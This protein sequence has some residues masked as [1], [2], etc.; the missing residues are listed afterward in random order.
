MKLVQ[1]YLLLVVVLL[2]SVSSVIAQTKEQLEKQR[3]EIEKEIASLEKILGKTEKSEK[4]ALQKVDE[5]NQQIKTTEK[6]I[7][8]NNQEA[9]LLSNQIDENTRNIEQLKKQLQAL[10]NEYAKMIKKSYQS[11]S[12]QNRIMFLFSSESF[13]QAYKRI[14]YMNQHAN[15]RKKQGLEIGKQTKELQRLNETLFT[16]KKEKE[17]V[18]ESNRKSK[19]KLVEKQ[20]EQQE[21]LNEIKKDEKKYIA[22]IKAQEKE[23]NRL[24]KEI[25][26]LIREAI[27]AENKKRG[28]SSKAKFEL[29]PEA[30]LIAADFANN[31]GRLPWPLKAGLVT[32]KFGKGKH[33]LVP[34][35]IVERKSIRI[36]TEENASALC[37][38]DGVVYQVSVVRG[39]NKY[40]IVRH[41]NY[42]TT[43]KNLDEIYV[44]SGQEV[45]RGEKLGKI[46]TDKQTGETVLGFSIHK[47]TDALDPAKWI[48][49]MN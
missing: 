43:Y 7:R 9:N 11:N 13:L 45:K 5:L 33:H 23:I 39:R 38:F 21:L 18:L 19:S 8:V 20:K 14:Q 15:Y 2:L 31:K 28:S 10:K 24:E 22:E 30:K 27:A 41:G 29:T 40:I 1:S 49:Q 4:S 16:Q 12:Q 46:A 26:R 42:I 47:N 34:S 35:V 25:D 17:A 36:Q 44:K 48:Y 6:L 3:D 37:I 32:T